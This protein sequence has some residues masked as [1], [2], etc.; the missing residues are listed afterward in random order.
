MAVELEFRDGTHAV[1]DHVAWL[2]RS[3]DTMT[4]TKEQAIRAS[5]TQ[6]LRDRLNAAQRKL[7]MSHFREHGR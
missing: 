7:I 5:E 6:L 4:M 1:A 3:V 2:L